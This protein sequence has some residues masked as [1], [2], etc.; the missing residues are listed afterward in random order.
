ML[1]RFAAALAFASALWMPAVRA[2]EPP[3][4]IAEASDYTKT[5]T[6]D[7]VEA[8]LK[9]LAEQSKRVKLSTIGKTHEGRDNPLAIISDPLVET[10]EAAAQRG[11]L[12]VLVF[13]NIHS[14][15]CDGKEGLLAL[16]R[17]LALYKRPEGEA[18]PAKDDAWKAEVLRKLVILAVPNYNADGNDKMSPKNRPGQV[19]PDTMGTRE[20]AQGFDLNRDF[21][22]LEAPETRGL[23]ETINKWDPAVLVDMHTTN[24]SFHRYP[25]TWDGPKHPGGDAELIKWAREQMLPDLGKGVKE[26]INLDTFWY[27]NFEKDHTR[28]E[29]Y[30]D[31]PRYSI[32]YFG[33]RNRIGILTESYSYAT[34]KER[35]R[36]QHEFV[37]EI[38]AYSAENAG[39]IRSLQKAAD[40]RASKWTGEEEVAISS[41]LVAAPEKVNVLGFEEEVVEGKRRPTTPKDYEVEL[42]A[43]FEPAMKVKKPYAYIL[44]S[45]ATTAVDNLR[46]HGIKVELLRE[47]I[48]L[49][50]EAQKIDSVTAA[51]M[52]F[53]GHTLVSTTTSA[54]SITQR[55]DAGSFVV[56]TTQ[57]FGPLAICFLEPQSPDGLTAWN[58]FDDALKPEQRFPVLRLTKRAPLHTLALGAL[59]GE[60]KEKIPLTFELL[61]S[62]DFPNL[63]GS[64]LGGFSWLEDG[65]HYLQFRD[66]KQYKIEAATGRAEIYLN[67]EP[68]INALAK[69]PTIG[70]RTAQNMVGASPRMDKARKVAVFE[71]GSDL[72]YAMADGSKAG[73]LTRTPEREEFPTLSPSGQFVAFVR[74]NDLWVA[75]IASQTEWPLSTGG[76]DLVRNAKHTWVYFEELYNRNWQ[77]FWWSPDSTK[78]AFLQEDA[79]PV[80]TFTLVNDAKSGDQ[81]VE[82]APYPK[83]GEPNPTAKLFIASVAGGEPRPVDLSAYTPADM[84]ITKL[85]WWPD[86]SALACFVSNRVQTWSDMLACPADGG[87]PR[88]LFRDST[89]AWIEAPAVLEFLK[90]GSFIISSERSGWQHLYK[91]AKDGKQQTQLTDGLW[92]VRSIERFDE[93]NGVVYFA[94]TKDSHIASN[95]YALKL[96]TGDIRR[97]TTEPGSH[98]TEVSEDGLLF[99][100]TWSSSKQPAQVVLRATDTGEVVRRLD[101]N[102]VLDLA[103][104]RVGETELV[105]IP[106]EDGFVLEGS[107]TRPPQFDPTKKYPVWFSTYA[108]PHAPTVSDSWS[109]RG[110]DQ[111]LASAGYM[112]FRADPRSAS[113][114]GAQSAWAAYKQL[115]VPELKDIEAA[116][117]WLCRTYPWSDR[118]RVGIQGHSYG[119]FMT[120]FALTHSDKFAA[121]IA[122]APPTDWRDYDSIYT[123]RYMLTPQENPDGYDATSAVKAAAKLKGRLLLAHGGMDDNV[124]AQNTMRLVKAFQDAARQFDL[125]IYPEN[126]HGIGGRHYQRLQWEFIQRTLG[127]PQAPTGSLSPETQTSAERD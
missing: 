17:E 121:G 84:L 78:I 43:T 127:G 102:P 86:S 52:P 68:M 101:I 75:E 124:H 109:V 126:R 88:K 118:D 117:D 24:G 89:Q 50:L 14:G 31:L 45:S 94:G 51:K 95:L 64:P 54:E 97:L 80:K 37:R 15:E 22:K 38:L 58:F 12:V 99:I 65:K 3:K 1:T 100:D 111:A 33:L 7:E 92:E 23:V 16:I 55:I 72:Y 119:G 19:G 77:A 56:K 90:D 93:K 108:G 40:E 114:K 8:F 91:Y 62:R 73:R 11:K 59:E 13:A 44:P 49:D 96:D 34:Y 104:Y 61:E 115:G 36:V 30:P 5:S 82:I 9:T 66:G 27:G 110:F 81:G 57:P 63:S 25:L 106:L 120:A 48:E 26:R 112:V 2:Q 76:T 60:P 4:T 122:G 123:E 74:K 39:K 71:H 6:G 28:W 53:Q 67:T 29:T 18:Q 35:V 98:G 70:R 69:I 41:K 125:M 83:P 79:T 32:N 107:V 103:K 113:G 21:V 42:F 46:R 47:D 87:A 105:Q 85:S 10:P 116:I 20:N